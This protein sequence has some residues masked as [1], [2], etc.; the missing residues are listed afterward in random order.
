MKR[1][2]RGADYMA[3][4]V[5][6]AALGVAVIDRYVWLSALFVLVSFGW[7]FIEVRENRRA[8]R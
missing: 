3:R 4:A 7:W 5:A 8:R 2:P 6:Y 1:E